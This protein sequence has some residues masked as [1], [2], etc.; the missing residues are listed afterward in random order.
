MTMGRTVALAA[1]MVLVSAATGRA[2][3]LSEVE[4][5]IPEVADEIPESAPD[6]APES[7]PEEAPEREPADYSRNGI[8]V[9]LG[10]SYGIETF[11]DSANKEL[12]QQL[13]SIGYSG[14]DVDLDVDE[15][16]GMNGQIGYRLHPHFSAEF[17]FEWLSG[18]DGD[19]SDSEL[20]GGSADVDIEPWVSSGRSQ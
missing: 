12:N 6:E 8:Y 4:D 20:A 3:D 10:G 2:D 14:L 17:Q 13:S 11:D 9:G 16:L 18:F 5:D 19:F 1:A 7:E 15:T